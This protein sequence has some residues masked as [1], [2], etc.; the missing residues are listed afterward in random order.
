MRQNLDPVIDGLTRISPS[1]STTLLLATGTTGATFEGALMSIESRSPI[2]D[3]WFGMTVD[4]FESSAAAADATDA[5]ERCG[6]DLRIPNNNI[7]FQFTNKGQN[8]S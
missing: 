8:I 5:A 3:S 4:S 1:K 6:N 7:D 2:R